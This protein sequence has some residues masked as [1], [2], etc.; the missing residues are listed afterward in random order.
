MASVDFYH[1]THST[2]AEALPFLLSRTM[3]AGRKAMVCC[4]KERFNPVSTAIW[5]GRQDSWLPHGIQ[6]RD[7][8]DAGLCPIWITD[9]A[10]DN[11]NGS[12]FWFFLGGV[13]PLAQDP[14]ERV[15]VLFE[16]RDESAVAA[17]RAQWKALQGG[18]HELGYLQ[19]DESGR[20]SKRAEA[21]SRAGTG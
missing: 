3:E 13:E 12:S 15:F 2:A 4:P 17:A 16:A 7:E 1:L 10:S 19:Q 5:S 6:G 20:W 21:S 18:G 8:E 11:R 9:D 14:A